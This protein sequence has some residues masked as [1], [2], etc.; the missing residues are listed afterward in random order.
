MRIKISD[1]EFGFGQE[2]IIELDEI[3]AENGEDEELMAA[4]PRVL[5]GETVMVGDELTQMFWLSVVQS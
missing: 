3:L 1:C 4:L 2:D 5:A